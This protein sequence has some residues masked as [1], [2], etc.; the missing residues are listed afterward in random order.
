MTSLFRWPSGWDPLGTVRYM[1]RE[2]DR[3]LGRG[4]TGDPRRVGGGTYPPVNVLN[5][6][7]DLI[8]QCELAGV[9]REDIDLSITG[10]TLVIKGTK[11]PSVEADDVRFQR[12]ER[13][14]GQ[15]SRTVVLPDKVDADGVDAELKAGVLT[16]RLPKSEAAK[17][18]QIAV[19]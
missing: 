1:Q 2:M 12:Q 16:V 11:R 8:V 3:F 18:K 9:K 5:G 7:D 6:P 13:G 19:R 17:P 10:E 4:V 15:F 14:F